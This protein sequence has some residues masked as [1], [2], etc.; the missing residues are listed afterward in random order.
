MQYSFRNIQIRSF[1]TEDLRTKA[2]NQ[3]A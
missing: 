3:F 2:G 1:P